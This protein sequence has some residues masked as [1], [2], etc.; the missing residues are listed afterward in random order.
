LR[1][2]FMGSTRLGLQVLQD[3]LAISGVETVGCLSAPKQFSISYSREPVRNVLHTDFRPT[4]VTHDI[5]YREIDRGMNDENLFRWSDSI[6]P[7]AILVA[8]WH[9]MLSSR[10][11]AKAPAFGIHASLL[12]DLA[13]GAPLVWALLLGRQHTGVTMFKFDDGVDSGPILGQVSFPIGASDDIRALLAK[14]EVAT[15]QLVTEQIPLLRDGRAVLTPQDLEERTVVPQRSPA[16]GRID[17]SLPASDIERFVRALSHPYPGAFSTLLGE[18]LWIWRV[19]RAEVSEQ[20]SSE[21]FRAVEELVPSDPGSFV[22]L[23]NR[24]YI[25][26][27]DEVL[28]ARAADVTPHEVASSL[29]R[30]PNGRLGS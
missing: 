12:P 1:L 15:R 20:V 30:Q 27:A 11:L 10:W 24:I 29:F 25:R 23:N 13:G 28:M 16:D 5:P 3:V 18:P 26:C 22:T 17:W 6:K 8:G 14:A 4:C 19:S 21:L 9:H 7:D 2:L